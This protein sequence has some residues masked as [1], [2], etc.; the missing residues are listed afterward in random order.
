LFINRV[1]PPAEGATGALVEELATDLA[2]RGWHVTV[3]TG[4]ASGAPERSVIEPGVVV[5]RVAGVPFSRMSHWKRAL[6]YGSLYPLLLKRALQLPRHDVVITKTDPPLQLVLGPVI[7][8]IKGSALV[9]WAQDLY[10]EVAEALGVIRTRGLVAEACRAVSTWAL[11][12]HDRVIA[13][14]RCMKRRLTARGLSARRVHVIS[15]WPPE[16]VDSVAHEDNSFRAEHDL[17]DQ[18]VVMYSGNMGLAHPFDA[19]LDAAGYLE[20][21]HPEVRLVLVGKGPRRPW[22]EE[23]VAERGLDNVVLLPFQPKE[24]LAESLSAADLHLV[25][26][27]REVN[28]LVVPSKVYGV[29]AAG[30]PCLFLGPPDSEAARVLREHRCGDVLDDPTGRRLADR[31]IRWKDQSGERQAAGRRAR[32]AVESARQDAVEAFEE[33]LT[34]VLDSAYVRNAS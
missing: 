30:R 9:H 20:D 3:L 10:P 4:Q 17:N 1:F 22:I 6:A 34:G 7:K 15:N 5:H 14:G 23:H 19:M 2:R 26:M 27:R 8:A 13:V 24:R 32:R 18:F 16:T 25:S 21:T 28:G 33:V 11:R 12:R 29:L 31:I